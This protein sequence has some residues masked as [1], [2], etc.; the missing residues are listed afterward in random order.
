MRSRERTPEQEV[1]L[2]A[3]MKMLP[4]I[5]DRMMPIQKEYAARLDE[6]KEVVAR[7]KEDNGVPDLSEDVEDLKKIL[8]KC[9]IDTSTS[10]RSS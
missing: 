8:P 3:L 5:V 7:K 10:S 6:N 9:S 4:M 2:A 1:E